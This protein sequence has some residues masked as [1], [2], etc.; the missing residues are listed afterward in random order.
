MCGL[1]HS[2][3]SVAMS[4]A[5]LEAP[6]WL[7]RALRNGTFPLLPWIWQE[8]RQEVSVISNRWNAV[9]AFVTTEESSLAWLVDVLNSVVC[10]NHEAQSKAWD[11]E[12]WLTWQPLPS[13]EHLWLL[14][15][16]PQDEACWL[17]TSSH[18]RDKGWGRSLDPKSL[19]WLY[20]TPL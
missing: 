11:A 9:L 18:R 10:N 17:H 4:E 6:A 12:L 16:D 1:C 20:G 15:R 14:G 2:V 13:A 8:H 19:R 3:P 7:P 5:P